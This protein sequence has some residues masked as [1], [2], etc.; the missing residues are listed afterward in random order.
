M[1][2]VQVFKQSTEI[3]SEFE[4]YLGIWRLWDL[5]LQSMPILGVIAVMLS[6]AILFAF[7]KLQASIKMSGV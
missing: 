4:S 6:V 5:L 2:P 7:C 1:L 3:H